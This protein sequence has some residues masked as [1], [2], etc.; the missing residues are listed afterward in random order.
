V[1]TQ[2]GEGISLAAIED[3]GGILFDG[4]NFVIAGNTS[5]TVYEVQVTGNFVRGDTNEDAL[6]DIADG[7]K[8]LGYLFNGQPGVDCLARMD[9][10]DDNLIDVADPIY[11]LSFLFNA[12]AAPLAP[13]P[14][15]GPDP[16]PTV[17]IPCP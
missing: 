3:P 15:P 6:V 17:D 7:I 11:L 5:G 13:F 16:T 12:G 4:E 9:I 8:C 10:N 1:A 14:D 2:D